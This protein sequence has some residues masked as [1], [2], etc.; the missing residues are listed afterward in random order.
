MRHKLFIMFGVLGLIAAACGGGSTESPSTTTD[1]PDVE[2]GAGV[3][4][5]LLPEGPS[6]LDDMASPELP[7]PLVDPAEIISGGPPPDGIPPDR[8]P[9]F[10]DVGEADEWMTDAEPVVVPR[11]RGDVHAYPVQV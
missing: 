6:A 1:T 7:E 10:V 4:A 2:T 5:G 8:Q 9:Q 3:G 11:D